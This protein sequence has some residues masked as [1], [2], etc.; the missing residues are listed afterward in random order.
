MGGILQP[1]PLSKRELEIAHLYVLGHKRC[2]IAA[3]IQ[4][5]EK[6]K[7]MVFKADFSKTC[8]EKSCRVN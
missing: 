7:Q 2:D 6:Y 3:K 4:I 8:S 1:Y 5:S